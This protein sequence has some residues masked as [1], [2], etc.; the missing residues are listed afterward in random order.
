MAL[1]FAGK[2][3]NASIALLNSFADIGSKTIRPAAG[4]IIHNTGQTEGGG[5]PQ[6]YI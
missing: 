4:T 2:E 1:A 5:Q 3:G 6:K